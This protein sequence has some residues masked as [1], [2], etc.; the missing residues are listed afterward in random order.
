[1]RKRI[2][3]VIMGVVAALAWAEEVSA[4]NGWEI[5]LNTTTTTT[6]QTSSSV[7]LSLSSG[8][9]Q[10]DLDA[11]NASTNPDEAGK[12][13]SQTATITVGNTDGYTVYVSGNTNLTGRNNTNH[14]IPSIT[15][16]KTLG[17][18]SNEWGYYGVLGDSEASYNPSTS[19]KAMTTSQQSVGTG[20]ATSSSVTKKLTLFY[21]AR[22]NNSAAEDFYG[23][24]VTLSVVAQPRTVTSTVATFGGITQM[25]QL[26]P[27]IC[28]AANVNDTAFLA[29]VRDGKKYWVTKM[30]D[31]NCWMSQNLDFNIST[32][33][34]TTA[35]SDVKSDWASS[36][37]YPPQ[38][39]VTTIN[40]TTLGYGYNNYASTYSWDMGDYVII[41]PTTTTGCS[42]NNMG[43]SV[44]PDQFTVIGS[45]TPSTDPNFF[46]N[47]GATYTDVEYDAHYL[48]GNHYAWNTAAA[49]TGKAIVDADASGSICPKNW[50]LPSSATDID[51]V[52][53]GTYAYLLQQYGLASAW[54]KGSLIG[55]G[56]TDENTYNIAL[57][58]LF[59]V[60]GGNVLPHSSTKFWVA[61]GLGDY[62]SSR[63]ASRTSQAY[64][65]S[66]YTSINPSSFSNYRY[67]G[68]SLRCLVPTF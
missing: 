14:K 3:G 40:A 52:T 24:T 46:K 8:T 10:T 59:F 38:T 50:K 25:Q 36:S 30:L 9:I 7:S 42:N 63:A 41:N 23:N 53:E 2:V 48:V 47:N 60:R 1:M 56:S 68:H 27:A 31:G 4:A 66:I 29:D 35:T 18:M 44:C 21:G 67:I 58:P 13:L 20:G 39:T 37:S 64:Y 15:S 49:G 45:R 57:S 5:P 34:V 65:L 32:S 19:F 28:K 54:D 6:S 55:T 16:S 17:S 51:T 12:V 11:A 22:V 62:W 33:N 61:G 26:T 43:P